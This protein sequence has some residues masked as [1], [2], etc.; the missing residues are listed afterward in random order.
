MRVKGLAPGKDFKL[1]PGGG[2][3]WDWSETGTRHE[4]GIQPAD[5]E[6]LLAHGATTVVLS[7]GMELRLLTDQATLAL[8]EQHGVVVHVAGTTEAVEIYNRLAEAEPV[9]GLFHSTC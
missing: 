8:L 7:R 2:R 6:E 9:G 5:V 3:D 4:P 1:Y